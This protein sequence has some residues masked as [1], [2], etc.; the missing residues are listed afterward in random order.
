MRRAAE[1][2]HASLNKCDNPSCY[3]SS[4]RL[5]A[6]NFLIY[7][8]LFLAKYVHLFF[9]IFL[10]TCEL[11]KFF[12]LAAYTSPTPD[13]RKCFILSLCVLRESDREA[14][15]G[16][17]TRVVSSW[18]DTVMSSSWVSSCTAYEQHPCHRLQILL[19]LEKYRR[20]VAT[21]VMTRIN[22]QASTREGFM[23]KM[24]LSDLPNQV[25]SHL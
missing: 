18:E 23:E 24:L 16:P 5:F 7:H 19:I 2:Q 9:E 25:L 21:L 4:L 14:P 20:K 17:R 1:P 13:F 6:L 12:C 22:V 10:V 8:F 11:G 15:L 3:S